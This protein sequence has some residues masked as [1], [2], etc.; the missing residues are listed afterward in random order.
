MSAAVRR[1]A[2]LIGVLGLPAHQRYGPWLL[3]L[4][5]ARL[6]AHAAYPAY[7]VADASYRRV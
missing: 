2:T 5:A 3:R 7:W 4:T 1:W 6:L